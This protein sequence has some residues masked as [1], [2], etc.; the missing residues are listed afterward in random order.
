MSPQ[1]SRDQGSSQESGGTCIFERNQPWDTACRYQTD[2]IIPWLSQ[3]CISA[4]IVQDGATGATKQHAILST[5]AA[6]RARRREGANYLVGNDTA[7]RMGAHRMRSRPA[8][9][10]GSLR[11]LRKLWVVAGLSLR[12]LTQAKEGPAIAIPASS[13]SVCSLLNSVRSCTSTV[14]S[15]FTVGCNTV[16][17]DD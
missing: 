2:P 3:D 14:F 5:E 6:F 4:P 13:A 7:G 9:L 16:A 11:S 12:T 8:Y 10:V 1:R 17:I 15:S